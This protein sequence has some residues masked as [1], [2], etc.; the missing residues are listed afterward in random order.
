[1]KVFR[2]LIP[3]QIGQD[4]GF[5]RTAKTIPTP[6]PH[7]ASL[8][9]RVEGYCPPKGVS[10]SSARA[11]TLRGLRTRIASRLLAPAP[12]I[13]RF[14]Y[15]TT[16]GPS[17]ALPDSFGLQLAYLNSAEIVLLASVFTVQGV[18]VP[19]QVPALPPETLQPLSV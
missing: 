15:P 18:V 17:R 11:R 3:G 1:M 10:P 6:G 4:G 7:L 12:A 9:Q 13:S 16:R 2:R 8:R 5:G 14:Y 19:V